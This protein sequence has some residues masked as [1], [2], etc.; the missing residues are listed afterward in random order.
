MCPDIKSKLVWMSRI[1]NGIAEAIECELSHLAIPA[2]ESYDVSIEKEGFFAFSSSKILL[3]KNA[4]SFSVG[5]LYMMGAVGKWVKRKVIFKNGV[6]KLF[7]TSNDP[8]KKDV[9]KE[10]MPVG[11]SSVRVVEVSN[12]EN[13]FQISGSNQIL[14]LSSETK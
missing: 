5:D 12:R 13:C 9:L 14:M 6:L 2:K 11:N 7:R 10:T 1:D 3:S 4:S 8:N